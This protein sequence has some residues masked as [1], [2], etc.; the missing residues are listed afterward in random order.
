MR[1]FDITIRGFE[2]D[3]DLTL[4]ITKTTFYSFYTKHNDPTLSTTLQAQYLPHNN[5]LV[6]LKL[7]RAWSK[8]DR[9]EL[10]SV[11]QGCGC[12]TNWVSLS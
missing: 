10:F 8:T 12:D 2:Q 7:I 11:I 9:Q 4:M 5:Q 3:I 6:V 1:V